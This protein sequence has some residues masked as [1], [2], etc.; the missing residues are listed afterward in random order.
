MS[1]GAEPMPQWHHV[2]LAIAPDERSAEVT[3]EGRTRLVTGQGAKETRRAA[4]GAIAEYATR[5]GRHVVIDAQDAHSVWQLVATPAGVVRAA[6]TPPQPPQRSRRGRRLAVVAV[7]GVLAVG[8]LAGAGVAAVRLL[9][10]ATVV[11]VDGSSAP[12]SATFETRPAPPGFT[13]QADWRLPMA[14]GTRPAVALDGSAAALIDPDERLMVVGP[15]G[16]ETWSAELPVEV[17]DIDGPLRFARDGDTQRVVLVGDGALWLWPAGGGVPERFDLPDDAE[18]SFAGTGPLVTAGD[19]AFVPSFA[20]SSEDSAEA[21]ASPGGFSE[22]ELVRVEPPGGTGAML[23]DGGEV[24]AA[25]ADGPWAWAGGEEEPREVEADRPEGAEEVDRV[26]TASAGYV[27]VRWSAD[28]EDRTV[29]AV[30]DAGD[31]SVTASAAIAPDE[32]ED[33]RWVDG[34]RTAAYGP[35]LVD[36]ADGTTDVLSGFIPVNAAGD[37]LYG[38]LDGAPVAVGADGEPVELEED[39]ARPW[40]LLDGRAVVV[41]DDDLYALSPE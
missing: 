41:A 2:T 6:A 23:A 21:A 17:G 31:G 14:P 39:T 40:G 4:I 13:R 22:G 26:L 30:H 7:G 5:T 16:T 29:L 34:D 10:D 9:P 3:I 24:L 19:D 35:L 33:A 18:V 37:T 15:G 12:A 32:L 36:L 25:S 27:I 38:E 28:D 20:A 8:V 1:T 11:P